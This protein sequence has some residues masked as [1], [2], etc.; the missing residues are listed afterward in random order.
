MFL[1]SVFCFSFRQ[2][3]VLHM[4][5]NLEVKLRLYE[6]DRRSAELAARRSE[7]AEMVSQLDYLRRLNGRMGLLTNRGSPPSQKSF[8]RLSYKRFGNS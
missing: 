3:R 6:I 5:T 8:G 1:D 2:S 4:S 7:L